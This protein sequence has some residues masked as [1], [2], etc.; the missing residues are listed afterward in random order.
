MKGI[1]GTKIGM[2]QIW[3]DNKLIPVTVV[4]A[5]PC[6]VVQRK[7]EE[8]DGYN[9][10]QLGWQEKREK[11]ANKPEL[12]HVKLAKVKPQK[13]L[14]EFRD[15]DFKEDEVS[16]NIF[17]AV[18]KVD[19]TGLSK[20]RGTAG[21]MKRWNFSGMP[22]THG[23]KKKHRS[24]GSIGQSKTP[25]RVYKGKRMAGHYGQERITTIGLELVEV[26]KDDNII[27]IKGSIPGSNG[28]MVIVKESRRKVN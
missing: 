24:P 1:L 6:P 21:V 2:T 17:E 22:A 26:R 20:G 9:A 14:V 13:R 28:A 12:G 23:V 7:T 11:S 15:F 27:L 3:Q 16:V 4:L 19:V 18:K 25:G 10:I 8:R 5:G